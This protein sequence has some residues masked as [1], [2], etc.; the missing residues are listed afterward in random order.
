MW[1]PGTGPSAVQTVF[2]IRGR[3][4]VACRA[5]KLRDDR[6]LQGARGPA[7]RPVILGHPEQVAVCRGGG[8]LSGRLCCLER[9]NFP[10]VSGHIPN[11]CNNNNW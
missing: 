9:F 7:H 11:Y 5:G 2:P 1:K 6:G 8:S 10:K 3:T 4:Q